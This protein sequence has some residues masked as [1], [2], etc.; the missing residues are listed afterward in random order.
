MKKRTVTLHLVETNEPLV[1][2]KDS[3]DCAYGSNGQVIVA[4]FGGKFTVQESCKEI[5]E[6]LDSLE[7]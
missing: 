6:L 3:F 5:G 2:T 4:M 7:D 1:F